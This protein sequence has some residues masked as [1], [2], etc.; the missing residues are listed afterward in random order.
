MVYAVSPRYDRWNADLLPL[1]RQGL[2]VAEGLGARFMLPGNVYNHGAG[3]PALLREDTPMRPTTH[4]GEQRVAMEDELQRRA[5]RGLDSVVI[6]A[7]A[8]CCGYRA[9]ATGDSCGS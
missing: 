6:R 4:K 8:C 7:G 2:A 3:M 9:L 5:A 1:L